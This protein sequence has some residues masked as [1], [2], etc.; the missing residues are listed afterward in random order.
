VVLSFE[1][2]QKLCRSG[3]LKPHAQNLAVKP[4]FRL[5]GSATVSGHL[6]ISG[7]LE[8]SALR[9]A[10]GKDLAAGETPKKAEE[11][12]IE[13]VKRFLREVFPERQVTVS[14]V[15]EEPAVKTA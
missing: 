13:Q 6:E 12:L 11:S 3:S 7:F 14:P 8:N 2:F 4:H 1:D 10:L 9:V 5:W 15:K